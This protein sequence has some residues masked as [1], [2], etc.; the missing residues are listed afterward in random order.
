MWELCK[1]LCNGRNR[2]FVQIFV[3][4]P[5]T[6]APLIPPLKV[7][8][9]RIFI[10]SGNQERIIGTTAFFNSIGP[11]E[12]GVYIPSMGVFQNKYRIFFARITMYTTMLL[13]HFSFHL[14]YVSFYLLRCIE[15][16]IFLNE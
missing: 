9:Y 7:C 2:C 4:I 15:E 16:F 14:Y 12:K 1:R 3:G 13:L 5:I 11:C 8:F 10:H 6:S